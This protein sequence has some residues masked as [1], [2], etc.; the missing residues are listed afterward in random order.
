MVKAPYLRVSCVVALHTI[1]KICVQTSIFRNRYRAEEQLRQRVVFLGL[2]DVL[3]NYALGFGVANLHELL[4]MAERDQSRIVLTLSTRPLPTAG[5]RMATA[6][7]TFFARPYVIEGFSTESSRMRAMIAVL[8]SSSDRLKW[9]MWRSSSTIRMVVKTMV[10]YAVF[11]LTDRFDRCEPWLRSL[12]SFIWRELRIDSLKY[13]QNVFRV[14][15]P[16]YY[17]FYLFVAAENASKDVFRNARCDTEQIHVTG[18]HDEI[19]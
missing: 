5:L 18:R 6:Y 17:R 14:F 12:K 3:M 16:F 2:V 9:W 15:S 19:Q 10:D 11:R 1:D 4:A 13:T 8:V 7:M